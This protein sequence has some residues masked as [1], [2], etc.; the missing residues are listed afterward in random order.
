[1]GATGLAQITEITSQLR[2]ESGK[3]QI[4]D[5]EIGLTH[6]LAGFATNHIVHILGSS[7]RN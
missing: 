1:M 7:P 6:N 3:R 5:A 2:G 4:A